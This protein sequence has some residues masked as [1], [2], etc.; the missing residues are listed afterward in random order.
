MNAISSIAAGFSKWIDA[1]AGTVRDV[2]D[3]IVTPR[4]VRLV[5][6]EAGEFMVQTN[7]ERRSSNTETEWIRIPAGQ[8]DRPLPPMQEAMLRNSRVELL[9]KPEGFLF[10]PLELPSRATEFVNGIVQN[11]IDR[12][13]PWNAADVAFGWS[14]PVGADAD[15]MVITVAATARASIKPYVEALVGL[16]VH[17]IA[18]LTSSPETDLNP[19]KVWEE[20]GRSGLDIG[21]VRRALLILLLTAGIAAGSATVAA[22]VV[23]VRLDDQQGVIA[24][25]IE[26]ARS[27]AGAANTAVSSSMATVQRALE[28]RKYEKPLIVLVIENLSRILPDHTYVT[29]LRVEGDKLRLVGVTSDAPSLIGLMEQ[30]GQFSQATFFAPTLRS[31]LG[32]RERFHIE[33]IIQPVAAAR[34]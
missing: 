32:P 14:K 20:R 12:L 30:S 17:S 29:E 3:R 9:M 8:L 28:Q 25:Q 1:V 33:A 34:S 26:T 7:E 19:I 21:V 31:D 11:Q 27:K 13:T 5:E 15:R 10:R 2:F 4:S 22:V 6:Q 16:G 23:G 24:R 18:V